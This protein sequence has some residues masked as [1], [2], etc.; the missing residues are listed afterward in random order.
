MTE[1]LPA[2]LES[3]ATPGT[4]LLDKYRVEGVLGVGGMGAVVAATHLQLEE[5]VAIKFLFGPVARS[6]EMVLRFLREG[7]SAIKIRSEHCVRIMDVGTLPDGSPYMV[8]EHLKG[9]DM[10]ALIEAGTLPV[11]AAVDFILQAGEALAEAHMLG[12]VHRDLKPANLFVSERADGSPCVKVLDFGISKQSALGGA[13]LSMTKTQA[14]MGSPL[15]MSPEQMRSSKDVDARADI[16]ALGAVL[17]ESLSGKPPFDGG[18]L[19]ELCVRILQDDPPAITSF[20][21]DIPPALVHAIGMALQKSRDRRFQNMAEFAVAVAPFGTQ[22]ARTSAERISRVIG[23]PRAPAPSYPGDPRAGYGSDPNPPAHSTDANFR[24]HPSDPNARPHPSD[25]GLPPGLPQNAVAVTSYGQKGTPNR[26]IAF[27]GAISMI[28]LLGLGLT[29]WKV[30]KVTR[31][32]TA[33]GLVTP[34]ASPVGAQPDKPEPSAPASAQ[35]SDPPPAAFASAS[36]TPPADTVAKPVAAQH[37]ATPAAR[38]RGLNVP[39]PRPSASTGKPVQPG[40]N[41][42]VF[43]DRTE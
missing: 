8:M 42:D 6:P 10:A 4:V 22:S 9:R 31:S 38:P 16:W 30:A 33:A 34:S 39:A 3:I 26:N 36:A 28:V 12:I 17:Y 5:R 7:R 35:P 32:P 40:K 23:G 27:I 21:S 25:P 37:E 15:Y 1:Q 41:K 43:D 24:P 18:S 29:I 2:E 14:V 13:D 20:R 19:T 11:A